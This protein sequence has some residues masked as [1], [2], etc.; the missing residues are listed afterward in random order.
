M[1]CENHPD[2]IA[3]AKC[4]KCKKEICHLCVVEDKGKIFCR[5][6]YEKLNPPQSIQAEPAET[7]LPQKNVGST[8]PKDDYNPFSIISFVLGIMSLFLNL[9]ASIPAVIFGI[10]ARQQI[11][12]SKGVQKGD[13][14]A[15]AGMIMGIVISLLWLSIFCGY[16]SMIGGLGSMSIC[17]ALG[18]GG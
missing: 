1:R 5:D 3:C 8:K 16:F 12:E 15:L 10:I 11:K 13:E 17:A 2:I 14:F 9:L 4:S 18:S 6:C 7:K